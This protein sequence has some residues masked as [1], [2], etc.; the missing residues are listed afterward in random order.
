MSERALQKEVAT[1]R[2]RHAKLLAVLRLV[3]ALLRVTEI[4]LTRRQRG[5]YPPPLRLER[6]T[7]RPSNSLV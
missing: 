7:P 1:L 3:L 5:E 4:T 6:A 2:Q